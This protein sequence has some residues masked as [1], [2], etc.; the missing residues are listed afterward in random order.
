MDWN[1]LRFLLA[2]ADGGSLSAAARAL[3]VNH[4]TV[5][6]RIARFET[7][8]G[9]RLFERLP[10]GYALTK[11]GDAL[12]AAARQ[13]EETVTAVERRIEGEDLRLS[14][15]VRVATTDTLSMFVLPPI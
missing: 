4:T 3:D 13:V 11:G 2:V 1:D 9:L 12:A 14:G 8:L 6:R 5:L 7:E 15:V 10:T